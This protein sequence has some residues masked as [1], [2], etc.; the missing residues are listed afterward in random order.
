MRPNAAAK[1][2]AR[3]D[4]CSKTADRSPGELVILLLDKACSCL[5]RACLLIKLED[6]LEWEERSKNIEEFF[7]STGRATQI[8]VA[9]REMLDMD[10][11]GALSLQLHET[12]TL[13]ASQIWSASKSKNFDDLEK[14]LIALTEL[15]GAW[16]SVEPQTAQPKI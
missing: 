5:R 3:T 1:A 6:D 9:L 16:E 4:T 10:S 11:G 7:K 2:Y 13:L 14:M 8:V 15:R 12:Y